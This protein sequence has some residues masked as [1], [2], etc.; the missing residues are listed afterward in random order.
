MRV[1]FPLGGSRD[2]TQSKNKCAISYYVRMNCNHLPQR[3]RAYGRRLLVLVFLPILG[4]TV[5]PAPAR[6]GVDKAVFMTL[7]QERGRQEEHLGSI[8]AYIHVVDGFVI[9]WKKPP[10]E[11]AMGEPDTLEK[12]IT[13]PGSGASTAFRR[14]HLEKLPPVL[15]SLLGTQLQLYDTQGP[16]C[17]A[18]IVELLMLGQAYTW[19]YGYWGHGEP[20]Y[21]EPSTRAEIAQAIWEDSG[22]KDNL[23]H[24]LGARII[25]LFGSC[26]KASWAQAA[27]PPR[28]KV[29][30]AQVASPPWSSAALAQF[31]KLLQDPA[32]CTALNS[33]PSAD[34]LTS[35]KHLLGLLADKH[36]LVPDIRMF[37]SIPRFGSLLTISLSVGDYECVPYEYHICEAFLVSGRP[38]R[39][40]FRLLNDITCDSNLL[41]DA[42]VDFN[43]DGPIVFLNSAGLDISVA[44]KKSPLSMQQDYLFLPHS[45]DGD[46]CNPK[47][48][49][50]AH[51]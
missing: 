19:D 5:L 44:T 27:G 48:F 26:E 18:R 15:P 21:K 3:L 14:V 32:W 22:K 29:Y 30:P 45:V 8:P 36:P 24:S 37:P 51:L 34:L 33:K 20:N 38:E 25:P 1:Q 31:N 6:Q 39:A 46:G 2:L 11:W 28:P 13:K 35:C 50:P 9:L 43:G 17:Q 40:E 41:P 47:N 49:S 10:E 16:V 23:G 4:C 12:Q 42:A 7:R